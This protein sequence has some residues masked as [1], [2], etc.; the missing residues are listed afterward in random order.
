M[1][2]IRILPRLDVKND[3]VVKGIH[4]EGLRVVGNPH[5]FA[6]KYYKEGIDEIIYM[7]VVA[8]LY[9]RNNLAD[10]VRYTAEHV[11]IPLT[12]GGGVRSLEDVNHPNWMD[13]QIK[14]GLAPGTLVKQ[15]KKEKNSID[16]ASP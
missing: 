5:E 11:F 6:Y 9:E 13:N 7:D 2:K 3:T 4:L 12:V 1:K 10:I 15:H 14:Q 16:K 8:S